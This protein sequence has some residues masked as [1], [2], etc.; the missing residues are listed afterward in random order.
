VTAC[1]APLADGTL[2]DY[3]LGELPA[4]AE[5]EVET[6]LM[7]CAECTARAGTLGRLGD[8]I[9]ALIRDG[10]VVLGL[11]RA[12]RERL[13][14]DGVRIRDH[15]VEPGGQTR[16]T[17]GPD[18]DLVS[19]AL[20]GEFRP[21]ER[22]DLVFLDAPPALGERREDVPVD[23]ER[24]EVVIAEPG[25]RIRALPAHVATVRLYGVGTAGER[26]IGEYTLVHTPWPGAPA[27]WP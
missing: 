21:G 20:H 14:R 17:A 5:A 12:L 19:L 25:A 22:V 10:R 18:D 6:H 2:L 11:T 3:R 1:R 23:H 13:E 16:C 15:R 26:T 27:D 8:A 24:G 4:A 9:A 7:A